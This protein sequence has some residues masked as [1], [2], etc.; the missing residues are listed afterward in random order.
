MRTLGANGD[1]R[2]SPRSARRTRRDELEEPR[3]AHERRT[4]ARLVDHVGHRDVL[5]PGAAVRNQRPDPELLEVGVAQCLEGI[6]QA[7][8]DGRLVVCLAERGHLL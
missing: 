6:A 1:R 3:D 7:L 2:A 8:V 4:A 5:H